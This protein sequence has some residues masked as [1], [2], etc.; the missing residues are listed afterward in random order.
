MERVRSLTEV[1]PFSLRRQRYGVGMM[2]FAPLFALC[3]LAGCGGGDDG[4]PGKITP[5]EE[6]ALGEAAEMID[7]KR[8]PGQPPSP[9][10]I[11]SPGPTPSPAVPQ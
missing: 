6:K 10:E 1:A 4:A 2:R 11:Q 7:A 8:L 3:F 9:D 5:D